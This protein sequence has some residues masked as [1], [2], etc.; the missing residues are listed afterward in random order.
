MTSKLS[1]KS[2]TIF[3]EESISIISTF[4]KIISIGYI[5]YIK[6]YYGIKNFKFP[7]SLSHPL[8]LYRLPPPLSRVY[9]ISTISCK[10]IIIP[11]R[12]E[13]FSI[14][15]GV[16]DEDKYIYKII[17]YFTQLIFMCI[18]IHNLL[19]FS[20]SSYTH[21]YN[22]C[23]CC[24]RYSILYDLLDLITHNFIYFLHH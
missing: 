10:R 14:L 3:I 2:D 16:K 1:Q 21:S 15:R 11:I 7:Y 22:I 20:F 6:F 4:I 5:L 8:Y 24:T 9:K 19:I 12:I 23:F 13:L 17:I 18:F